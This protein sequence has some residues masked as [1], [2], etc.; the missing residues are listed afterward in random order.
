MGSEEGGRDKSTSLPVVQAT[1]C[2]NSCFT[3]PSI[4]PS[5]FQL[6]RIGDVLPILKHKVYWVEF[7]KKINK[8]VIGFIA[9]TT[10][11]DVD[12][13]RPPSLLPIRP[14]RFQPIPPATNYT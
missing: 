6:S 13:S 7:I 3:I 5:R 9:W 14:P 11:R 1:R 2:S 8:F 12:L 4:L 10:G